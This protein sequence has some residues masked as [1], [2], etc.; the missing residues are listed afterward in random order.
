MVSPEE[1]LEFWLD[2]V[3]PDGWYEVDE[4]TFILVP[5][6]NSDLVVRIRIKAWRIEAVWD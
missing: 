1:V 4:R 5:V 3:G 2:E 6:T